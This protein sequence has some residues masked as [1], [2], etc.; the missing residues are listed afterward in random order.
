M[1]SGF[2]PTSVLSYRD[3]LKNESL[4]V[5]SLAFTLSRERMRRLI[6]A[7]VVRMPQRLFFTR[8]ANLMNTAFRRMEGGKMKIACLAEDRRM[9]D[10]TKLPQYF[11]E[12]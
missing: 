7:F 4:H 8:Q 5:A 6:C 3:K 1:S 11:L 10:C 2:P 12:I 9:Q